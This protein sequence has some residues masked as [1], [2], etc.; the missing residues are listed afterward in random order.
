MHALKADHID[1]F[2]YLQHQKT[3]KEL[4]QALFISQKTLDQVHALRDVSFTIPKGQSVGIIGGNGAGKSTLLKLMA[5]VSSPTT[6]TIEVIGRLVPLIE[7]GAGFHP[8][9][10]GRENIFL[11]GIILGLRE[12]EVAARFE[13]IVAFAELNQFIDMPV[14]HYSSGMFMRLAFSIAVSMD[15]DVLL[16]DE[17]LSVGDIT[18]QEKCI[19][20]MHSFREKGVTIILVS[21]SPDLIRSFCERTIVLHQGSIIHDGETNAGLEVYRKSL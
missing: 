21:H 8:E 9:L 7:L 6:G 3:L 12:E 18:F 10:S 1:K 2:F 14:K 13:D 5:R 11:N 20:R 16:V 19:A 4:I 15:P 17:V